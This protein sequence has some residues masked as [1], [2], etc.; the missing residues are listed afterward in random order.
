[1]LICTRGLFYNRYM[2]TNQIYLEQEL[3]TY[4]FQNFILKMHTVLFKN[5]LHT[6]IKKYNTISE[7]ERVY[8]IYT[9]NRRTKYTIYNN[10][11]NWPFPDKYSTKF[12]ISVLHLGLYRGFTFTCRNLSDSLK[13]LIEPSQYLII[14]TQI[15]NKLLVPWHKTLFFLTKN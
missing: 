4:L 14:R 7:L 8:Y 15:P 3:H 6:Q 12:G 11:L 10:E 13:N 2:V 5:I 1:M 9:P